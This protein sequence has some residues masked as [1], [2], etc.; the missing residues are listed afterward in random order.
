FSQT[1]RAVRRYFESLFRP[2]RRQPIGVAT[3][4]IGLTS[5]RQTTPLGR[6]GS[7]Y[8]TTIL[9][10]G[11]NVLAIEIW[12]E[13]D[14]VLS[15][16]PKE[17]SGAFVLPRIT[18]EEAMELSYFGAKVLRSATIAPAVA[19][20]IP[21]LIKNTFRPGAAGTLISRASGESEQLVKG[22]TSI[23]G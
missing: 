12:T 22:I 4:F 17:G 23:D 21:I 8:T 14:G 5:D 3:G 11:L 19:R 7:D 6:N 1:N 18:Y 9:G 16:A 10:A 15:A 20:G 13:L 2:G